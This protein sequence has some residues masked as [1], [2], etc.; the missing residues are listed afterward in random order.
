[1]KKPIKK[2]IISGFRGILNPF[3]LDFKRG[4]SNRSLV[5]YGKN[6]TGK[7]SITDAWEWLQT[8]KI[9]HLAREG[10]KEN[11]Y[12]NKNAPEDETYIEVHFADD[13]LGEVQLKFD[14]NRVT[15]PN[16]K[17]N[18]DQFRS[19]V[20]HPCQIRFGD[21]TRFVYLT[22]TEKYDALAQLMGFIPQVN[23]QKS[24]QRVRRQIESRIEEINNKINVS[25]GN[26]KEDLEL[27]SYEDVLL[28]RKINSILSPYKVQDVSDPASFTQAIQ[29]LT[30]LVKKDPRAKELADLEDLSSTLEGIVMPDNLHQEVIKFHSKLD[31]FKKL[32]EEAINIFLIDLYEGGINVIKFLKEAGQD[33]DKCPLCGQKYSGDLKEHIRSELETLKGTRDARKK[34]NQLRKDIKK[35]LAHSENIFST[36]RE[37]KDDLDEYLK[38]WLSDEFIRQTKEAQKVFTNIL[39]IASKK[40][41]NIE[42]GDVVLLENVLNNKWDTLSDYSKDVESIVSSIDER[43]SQ[44]ESD[45]EREKLVTNHSIAKN[46]LNDYKRLDKYHKENKKMCTMF[47]DLE[48]IVDDY[49]KSSIENVE[50]RFDLI[51]SDVKTY[52]DILEE[53]SEGLAKPKL[54]LLHEQDRAVVLEIEFQGSRTYPAY[55]Y[56]SESQLNSFG[57]SVFLASAKF[58][59]EKFRFL[60]LDDIINSFDAYKRPQVV[61]LLKEE[62]SEHQILLLTHDPVW[63]KRI[64][65]EFPTWVKIHINRYE[66]NSGPITSVGLSELDQIEEDISNDH[67]ERAGR[68]MG[69]YLE[70]QLQEICEAFEVFVK[71]NQINEYTLRPMLTRFRVR[72]KDKLGNSHTLHQRIDELEKE[73]A[74]RNFCAHWKN[75]TTPITSHEMGIVV[76]LWKEIQDLIRCDEEDCYG[77]LQYDGTGSFIC[78]CGETK[79]E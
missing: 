66:P 79:L 62:F 41:E 27:D 35:N 30:E 26:I 22:K 33:I 15:I 47:G 65:E 38:S 36:I 64:Y 32:E 16:K 54:K 67:P 78:S 5:I 4:N 49:V 63:A 57:L 76:E 34:I 20:P 7:S 25:K 28:F 43:E 42:A 23:F 19:I 2:I 48:Q 13:K 14:R 70:R 40:P 69:P 72:V 37:T 9:E 50:K 73:S 44:L 56:L 58:F 31:E 8:G 12:P 52:F 1:M 71:Y 77:F 10:A 45:E 55:R 24:L 53:S 3:P 60:V 29:E 74:F 21:L 75:P 68:Q 51:S 46:V 18:I 11:A 17:G 6:G 59:N 39:A 61:K